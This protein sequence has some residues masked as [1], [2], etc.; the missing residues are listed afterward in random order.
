MYSKAQQTQK[1]FGFF[2]QLVTSSQI[3][4]FCNV[5]IANRFDLRSASKQ[6]IFIVKIR[7]RRPQRAPPDWK[8]VSDL[9]SGLVSWVDGH[10][11]SG[12][13]CYY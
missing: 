13:T 4:I 7:Y 3:D 6:S 9:A 10:K 1:F 2:F 8:R 5:S 12:W 11:M